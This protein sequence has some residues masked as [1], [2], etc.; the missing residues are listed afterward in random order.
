MRI[1]WRVV[2]KHHCDNIGS[3]FWWSVKLAV[4]SSSGH[5]CQVLIV[6][7]GN[8]HEWNLFGLGSQSAMEWSRKKYQCLLCGRWLS[9]KQVIDWLIDWLN[10]W[11]IDESIRWTIGRSIGGKTRQQSPPSITL[12]VL[13][14]HLRAKHTG[15]R[16]FRCQHCEK[17]FASSGALRL[18]EDRNHSA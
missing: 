10:D 8:D 3:G 6:I 14:S 4:G 15:E 9:T 5:R 7:P 1:K 17:T 13:D 16:P 12:Q 2:D 18:H 11:L